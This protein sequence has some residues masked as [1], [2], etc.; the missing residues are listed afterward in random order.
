M[1]DSFVQWFKEWFARWWS[2]II[3]ILLLITIVFGLFWWWTGPVYD[4]GLMTITNVTLNGVP[5][6][7]VLTPLVI[8]RQFTLSCTIRSNNWA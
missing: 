6:D 3:S 4:P 7:D 2:T 8:N 1:W 5:M